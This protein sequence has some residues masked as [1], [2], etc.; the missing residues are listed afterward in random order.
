MERSQLEVARPGEKMRVKMKGGSSSP[1]LEIHVLQQAACRG[2]IW[3]RGPPLAWGSWPRGEAR[4]LRR[5]PHGLR[6]FLEM[7]SPHA[8]ASES[9]PAPMLTRGFPRGLRK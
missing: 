3:V 4:A 7:D 8:R 6:C 5:L 1:P 9:A 2:D